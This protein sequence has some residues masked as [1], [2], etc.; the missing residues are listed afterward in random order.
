M[1]TNTNTISGVRCWLWSWLVVVATMIN[2][3]YNLHH[4]PDQKKRKKTH[5]YHF[6]Q[7]K[8]KGELDKRRE[9]E[10][11]TGMSFGFPRPH[12]RECSNIN[13]FLQNVRSVFYCLMGSECR[14]SDQFSSKQCNVRLK[15]SKFGGIYNNLNNMKNQRQPIKFFQVLNFD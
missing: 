11:N 7:S 2:P 15:Y 10:I 13:L 1:N 9:I 8:R 5:G 12:K 3:W 6:N 4:H 14:N